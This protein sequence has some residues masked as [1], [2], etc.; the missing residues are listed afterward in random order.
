MSSPATRHWRLLTNGV[1]AAGKRAPRQSAG[2][3]RHWVVRASSASEALQ[4]AQLADPEA[5]WARL[6]S[7]EAEDVEAAKNP[8]PGVEEMS[9]AIWYEGNDD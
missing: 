2:F 4:I 7:V 8:E 9:G 1:P 6:L 5:S 3:Y